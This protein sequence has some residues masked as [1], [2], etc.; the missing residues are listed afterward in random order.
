LVFTIP[1]YLLLALK[2][3][4]SQG[5]GKLILKFAGISVIYNLI[6]WVAVGLVF[7]NALK[8]I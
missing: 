7:F 2:K 8:L 3:F 6:F 5:I 1:V 4:Y